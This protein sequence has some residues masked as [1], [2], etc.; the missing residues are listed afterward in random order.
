MATKRKLPIIVLC[1]L[2]IIIAI[3]I[4]A[5]SCDS[6][7]VNEDW[8]TIECSIIDTSDFEPESE[9]DELLVYSI[10]EECYNAAP[11]ELPVI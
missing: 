9:S 7:R 2:S 11:S 5:T 1:I 6:R 4:G 8:S 10:K 3:T